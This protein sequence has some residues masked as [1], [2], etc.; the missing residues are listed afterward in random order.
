MR[1]VS[2]DGRPVSVLSAPL[3]SQGSS[4]SIHLAALFSPKAMKQRVL[5]KFL[6]DPLTLST[7]VSAFT[8]RLAD[9][10]ARLHGAE[11]LAMLSAS[12]RTFQSKPLLHS[13]EYTERQTTVSKSLKVKREATQRQIIEEVIRG[14][15]SLSPV[16]W[17]DKEAFSCLDLSPLILGQ[18]PNR[19]VMQG[20][21]KYLNKGNK[22]LRGV[23]R[24]KILPIGLVSEVLTHRKGGDP[25]MNCSPLKY[26]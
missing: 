15:S 1:M 7:D 14:S 16:L 24:V 12:F 20:F 6:R 2:K 18:D 19:K 3:G 13:G 23:D 17:I 5:P 21:F 9:S 4:K 11:E 10:E 8:T 22:T 26:E 25:H